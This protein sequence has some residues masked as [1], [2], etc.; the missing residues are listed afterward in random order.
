[1][2]ELKADLH[3]HTCLSPCAEREMVP[4][5]IVRRARALGLDMIAIC[6]HNATENVAAVA[7][8]GKRQ[9]I[10]VIPGIEITSR[11]EVHVLGL[12]KTEKELAGI[13]GVVHENLAGENDPEAFG[14]QTI[15]D[16]WDRPIGVSRRL[17]IG[18]TK[19][20]LE[21]VV[22]A[23]HGFGGLAIA[24]HVDRPSFGLIGQLG[25]VPAGL[26]LDAVELSRHARAR[27]WAGFPVVTS[28]DAHRLQDIGR[29]FTRFLA[30]EA[31]VEELGRALRGEGGRKV[32][33][34]MQ[35]LSLHIL[36]VVENSISASASRI[37]ILIAED[38]PGDR[39]S[40][41]I[42]DNGKGMDAETRQKVLDPFYTTRSTRRVGL[43]LA[44]LAQAAREAG[45]SLEI[46]SQPGQGTTVKA[47]FQLSHPDRKPL[48]DIAETL[49]TILAGRP[50]LDLQFEYTRDSIVLA[51]LHSSPDDKE[52]TNGTVDD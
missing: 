5:A 10:S 18:A 48:G 20:N 27:K 34:S 44:L 45:G 23:I 43:G 37:K 14:P 21:E 39:L 29:G 4:T 28:S 7:S 32:S 52:L 42:S 22:E 11:E 41:E 36:D 26:K 13:Q 19:L 25:L 17:L 40:L 3:I 15:V 49:G 6:D 33:T 38:T 47:T 35:D 16:E 46:T 30:E 50:E 2:K 1:M 24:S 9:A 51:E 31:S 12:F 8:A